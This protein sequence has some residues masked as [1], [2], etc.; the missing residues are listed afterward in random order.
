[1]KKCE[2]GKYLVDFVCDELPSREREALAVHIRTCST[3]SAQTATLKDVTSA[4]ESRERTQ[5]PPDFLDR[6]E[7]DLVRLFQ[8]R[9]DKQTIYS[10]ISSAYRYLFPMRIRLA[11]GFTLLL[12]GIGI[13]Y[14]ARHLTSKAS[15]AML[16]PQIIMMPVS[17]QESAAI[18]KFLTD[19]EIILLSM[20][21]FNNVQDVKYSD[22][23]V[24][25]HASGKLV[26]QTIHIWDN[27]LLVQDTNLNKVLTHIDQLLLEIANIQETDLQQKLVQ[28][29]EVTNKE[30]IF[31]K[32]NDFKA[33][34]QTINP[35]NI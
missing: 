8:Q 15:R 26:S 4:L 9:R 20:T 14:Y 11:C 12:L 19:A 7:K 23:V 22:I 32:A 25:K 33:E 13:G 2:Y 6:F 1:M 3:C 5:P 18:C 10:G 16:T 31:R 30:K 28:I 29:R 17:S 24:Y 27:T 35:H 34:F 21:N